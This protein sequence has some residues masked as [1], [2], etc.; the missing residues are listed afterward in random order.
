MNLYLKDPDPSPLWAPFGA[1]RPI[2]E[3]RAGA[4]LI[5]ERNRNNR[6]ILAD[7]IHR[8]WLDRALV[9]HECII[10]AATCCAEFND[11]VVR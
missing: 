4:W 5:R 9:R 8:R 3:L 1:S 7:V 10:A 2:S 11:A 6:V